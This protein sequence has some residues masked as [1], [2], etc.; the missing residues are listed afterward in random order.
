MTRQATKAHARRRPSLPVLLVVILASCGCESEKQHAEPGRRPRETSSALNSQLAGAR[1][2]TARTR[3]E[4]HHPEEALALLVSALEADPTS[5]EALGTAE[6]ILSETIWAL[7]ET[8]LDHPA[9]IEHLADAEPLSLWVAMDGEIG[10]MA[11]WD[12]E[13]LQIESVLFPLPGSVTRSIT[14]DAGHRY[15]VIERGP[16]TLLCHA[17]TLKP[18]REIPG[19]P[20]FLTPSSTVVFSPDGLLLAHPVN[21]QNTVIWQVR[22]TATGELIRA[23][24][25]PPAN[26]PKPLAAFLDRKK[27][28]VIHEDGS[29]LEMPVSPVEAVEITPLPEPASLVQAQF[30]RDGHA[31]LTR[32]DR[33]PH[34]APSPSIIAY[35]DG[36]DGSLETEALM[37]R[38]PWSHHPNL[39]SSPVAA[40]PFVID[41]PSLRF[42]GLKQPAIRLKTAVTAVAFGENRMV[43]G[44]EAGTVTL[45]RLIPP[46]AKIGN[47]PH[48]AQT[49][50]T[51]LAS[52]KHLAQALSGV[53]YHE[54]E[55]TFDHLSA[56]ARHESMSRCDPAAIRSIFPGLEFGQC[57]E[58][59]NASKPHSA[60]PAATA[61]LRDRL[62]RADPNQEASIQAARKLRR[63]FETRDSDA[64]R[65]AIRESGPN[66]PSA[67][68]AL[69]L[70]LESDQTEWIHASLAAAPDMP[71]FLRKIAQSKI[72]WLAGRK[73]EALSVWPEVIPELSSI[74]RREDWDGW[75]Q[76]D[77]APALQ[78]VR[79]W[80]YDELVAIAVPENSS[81]EQRKRIAGRLK[82]PATYAAV[83]RARYAQACL[84]AALAFSKHKEEIE[85]TLELAGVAR[86]LGAA[87][88]PCLR[89]EALA[90]TALGDFEKAHPR[91]IALIT[92]HPVENHLPGDYAEAAYTA[93]ENSDPRQAMEILT[94]GLHRFPEDANYA[95]RAG[96]VALLS[97]NSERAYQFL[98]AGQRI[99]FPPEKLEN[100][101]A[102]LTIAAEQSGAGDD[103][104]VYFRDLLAIDPAWAEATT[105]D[106][107]EWPEELKWTL[108]QFMH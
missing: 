38:F 56:S 12:L 49:D 14:F 42:P 108:R 87:P 28:R 27:L 62:A 60:E 33:G 9:R 84:H 79:Q 43:T 97:G 46:P 3:L 102:L 94:T 93:F 18:I 59:F 44:E 22:D 21:E 91:W 50:R 104:T 82:D 77:F 76:A 86:K 81:A 69:A 95:L 6:T 54:S 72:D 34:A 16:T 74:R 78:A 61:S 11:R 15:A 19:I 23:S 10:S 67:A 30:S 51:T 25:Q 64:I 5:A 35:R 100:A 1:I 58:I 83:G 107:L 65:S 39:W 52:L 90:L 32:I 36:E 29:L 80:V 98:L 105:L 13:K 70:A 7:P 4:L 101:T 40:K 103:A 92:E 47:P 57:L 20:D 75:E 2:D 88:E 85:T 68:H 55:R 66:G 24:E 37:R 41:G 26:A 53:T 99:G 89:A 96:W 17:S 8:T 45:H 63:V 48:A 71:P 31:V 106:S 73:A